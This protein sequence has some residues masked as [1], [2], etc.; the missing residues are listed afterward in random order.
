[1]RTILLL[2]TCSWTLLGTATSSSA[3]WLAR[4]SLSLA[5]FVLFHQW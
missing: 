1:M 5:V 4:S 2:A 3:T